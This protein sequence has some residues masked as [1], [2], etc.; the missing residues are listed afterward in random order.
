[1]LQGAEDHEPDVVL[2]EDLHWIDGASEYFLKGLVDLLGP[3]TKT[4]LIVNTRP[5]YD[6]SWLEMDGYQQVELAPLDDDSVLEI[7]RDLLGADPSV[8]GLADRVRAETAGNPFFVEEVVRTLIETGKLTGE[9]GAYRLTNAYDEIAI[10]P[11]VHGVLAAR[12]DRLDD[13]LK[14][15]LQHAAVIGKRFEESLLASVIESPRADLGVSLGGLEDAGFVEQTSVVPRSEYAFTHP[16]T[17][18]VAYRTQLGDRRKAIHE[19]VAIALEDDCRCERPEESSALLA[20]HW[21]QAGDTLKAVKWGAAAAEWA[22]NRDLA[23]SRRHWQKVRELLNVCEDCDDSYRAAIKA[24]QALIE[25]N[26]KLGADIEATRELFEEGVALAQARNDHTV[27]AGL[28]AAFAMAQLFVGR[29]EDG[30]T[31]LEKAVQTAG[32]SDDHELN[33]QLVSRLAYMHLL[34]GHLHK[35]LK[36]FDLS[37][38]LVNDVDARDGRAHARTTDQ[39]RWS[40]GF[41]ALPMVYLGQYAEA[42]RVHADALAALRDSQERG[43]ETTMQGFGVTL[44]WFLGDAEGALEFARKQL[45]MAEEI[46]VPTLRAGAFDSMAVALMMSGRFGE[47]LDYSQK[48]LSTARDSGTLLQSEAVF[49]SNLCAAYAGIGDIDKSIAVGEEAVESARNRRTPMFE[50]RAR[51]HLARALLDVDPARAEETLHV[52]L[53]L[54]EQTDARGYEPFLREELART[55]HRRGDDASCGRETAAALRLFDSNGAP[56]Q[57]ERVGR[58]PDL[59]HES[60]DTPTIH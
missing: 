20:H 44:S 30:L 2:V 56:S 26:W 28:E 43:T 49:L 17:Q 50:I 48:A 3:S 40:G 11:T 37:V 29:V 4:L 10:P 51:L 59:C 47:A 22:T 46:R 34:S 41:R 24:R 38:E 45:L 5:G 23:E 33:L 27:T 31:Y 32:K 8:R 18:E 25:I 7:L 16:L 15:L 58:E 54:V 13:N 35:A 21:E 6:L 55:Y 39:G 12:I 36:M 52:A 14:D 9:A 53:D 42:A 1:M 60:S 57:F 19:R